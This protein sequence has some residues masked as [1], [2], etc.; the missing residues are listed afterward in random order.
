MRGLKDLLLL[1]EIG[2]EKR[3]G[4]NELKKRMYVNE[5]TYIPFAFRIMFRA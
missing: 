5:N 2:T 4:M 1:F 3:L